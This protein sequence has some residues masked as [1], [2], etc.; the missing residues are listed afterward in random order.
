M[1][2]FLLI[3][4]WGQEE[5]DT[6]PF[7]SPKWVDRFHVSEYDELLL[8]G[9]NFYPS[10]VEDTEDKQW[11]TKMK[12]YFPKHKVKNAILGNHDYVG[13]VQAQLQF[14]LQSK[15][16]NWNLPHFFHDHYYEDV[17]CH[18]FFIDT[19]LLSPM[20][21]TAMMIAC[22]VS[23]ERLQTLY[24]LHDKFEKSQLRWLDSGLQHSK[25]KWK[26]VVGHYP[27]ISN[28]SH[29]IS[30]ETKEKIL[31]LL[32]KHK[33]DIYA[34][35]HDHNLQ[36]IKNNDTHYVVTGALSYFNVPPDVKNSLFIGKDRGCF[37]IEVTKNDIKFFVW[38]ESK[39]YFVYHMIKN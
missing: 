17:D 36:L 22:N 16:F 21:T 37:S 4:D 26:I 18:I 24:R 15:N 32:D 35:G 1:K 25:A 6:I 39:E 8:L 2:K 34:S 31:P 13:N 7:F 12:K 14:S 23:Q 5:G 20:Y 30:I 38:T 29:E 10:G 27:I 19:Q 3:G 33:V 11:D 9:D 28:G